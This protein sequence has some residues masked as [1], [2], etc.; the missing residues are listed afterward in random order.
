MKAGASTNRRWLA[1]LLPQTLVARVF[2]LYTTALLG[3]VGGALAAFYHHQFHLELERIQLRT[4]AQMEVVAP[5]VADSAVIGD[6]D[7]IQRTL[8]RSLRHSDFAEAVF[9]DLHGGSIRARRSDRPEIVAPAWLEARV[10]ASLYDANQPI[11]VGGRDYGVLRLSYAVDR[12]AGGMWEQARAALL[13]ATL[14]LACG[15]LLIWL[16]LQHW[17]GN[18][19]RLQSLQEGMQAGRVGDAIVLG[20]DAP[21]EFRRTFDVLSRAA[22]DMQLQREQA[23]VTLQAI[24]DGVFTLDA[25]GRIV[26]VN[27]AACL[28]LGVPQDALIGRYAHEV[29]APVFGREVRYQPWDAQRATVTDALGRQRV[30]DTT[31]STIGGPGGTLAGHVLACRDVTHQ[32]ALDQRL[33]DEMRARQAAIA[34]LR[35]VL[36]GLVPQAGGRGDMLNDI[37][38]ISQMISDVTERLQAHGAQLGAIFDLSPDGFVSFDPGGAVTYVSPA[39]THLTGI[40]GGEVLGLDEAGFAA[41]LGQHC[42]SRLGPLS[43]QA[44]RRGPADEATARHLQVERPTRRTLEVTLRP[45]DG[46]ALSQILHLR[47]VTHETEVDQ[48]KS[49]FLSV[50]AHELRTPMSSIY[51]FTELMMTRPMTPQRQ[52]EVL[53]TVHRQTG[54]MIAIVNELLDLARIEARRGK[55]FVI[56]A[57]DLATLVGDLVRD[58]T[59]PAGRPLPRV[60]GGGE[61]IV[62]RADRGKLLQALSNLL[63]NAYKYSPGGGAVDITL[64]LEGTQARVGIRDHGIGMTPQQLER[65]GERFY[66]ADAS[67]SIPG[68]GLGVSI[69]KE[70][71]EL[72]GGRL[73]FAS[74]PG[75]GTE[76]SLWMSAVADVAFP[77]LSD[78]A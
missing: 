9:I 17:L 45:G 36:E 2:A 13:L 31:L 62:V 47:D 28:T 38:A 75:Q 73:A 10:E 55:D 78:A 68:T 77:V 4:D 72:L 41:R 60:H 71:V 50:A 49:E 33:R 70:I 43:I 61:S 58:F 15:L 76:V 64:A 44:F 20:E 40:E 42:E 6:Y 48:M 53:A 69:V 37:E 16:P 67:G 46:K 11:A 5:V 51:G 18:I 30:L 66:R 63:S 19:G 74:E 21:I 12:I 34:S 1:R 39:F 32:H 29:L 14:G 57:L 26:L 56:E 25:Q 7:T 35:G 59:P 52:K 22:A 65:M 3:F 27:P 23:A 54:L 8:E 24:G